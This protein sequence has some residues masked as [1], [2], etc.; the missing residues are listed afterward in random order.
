MENSNMTGYWTGIFTDKGKE[1]EIDFTERV[2]AKKWLMK[3]FVKSVSEKA[4][5]TVCCRHKKS[6]G[7]K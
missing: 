2:E 7:G 1:T 5:G 6:I 4:A 3:P